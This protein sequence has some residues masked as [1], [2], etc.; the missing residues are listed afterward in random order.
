VRT[1]SIA[2]SGRCNAADDPIDSQY[3]RLMQHPEFPKSDDAEYHFLSGV[4][5]K[6]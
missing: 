1:A 4:E 6:V 2:S 5:Q 3:M